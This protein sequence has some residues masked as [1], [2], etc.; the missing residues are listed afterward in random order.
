MSHS[1]LGTTPFPSDVLNVTTTHMLHLDPREQLPDPFLRESEAKNM[2]FHNA[3]HGSRFFVVE[4]L[5]FDVLEAC[6]AGSGTRC[7]RQRTRAPCRRCFPALFAGIRSRFLWME[8]WGRARQ[9]VE[10]HARGSL[11]REDG[12]DLVTAVT[13]APSHRTR[14]VPS[15][16]RVSTGTQRTTSG[17]VDA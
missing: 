5:F 3:H 4:R 15:L 16:S 1:F 17:P 7:V 8:F 6:V 14:T 9:V 13:R 2:V 11:L 12:V 10:T